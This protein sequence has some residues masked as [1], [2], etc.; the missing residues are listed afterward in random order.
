MTE[1]KPAKKA[2]KPKGAGIEELKFMVDS[3]WERRAMLTPEE[4]EGPTPRA[5]ERRSEGAAAGEGRV[6]EPDGKG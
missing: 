3:A 4:Q 6:D 2:S 5:V 1:R